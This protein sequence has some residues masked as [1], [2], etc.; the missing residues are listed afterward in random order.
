MQFN[1]IVATDKNGAIGKKGKIPWHYPEDLKFFKKTT[2]N[3]PV[4]MGRKTFES[5]PFKNGLPDRINI[6][7]TRN[8]DYKASQCVVLHSLEEVLKYLEDI[9]FYKDYDQC[10]C[11]SPQETIYDKCF[12]IGGGNIYKLFLD[13]DL[14]DKIYI[15]NIPED[16]QEADTFFP[17]IKKDYWH[18]NKEYKIQ[19][20]TIDILEN[21]C[22]KI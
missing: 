3:C 7:L 1:I 13:N 19:N 8:L 4:I 6:I 16:I 12:I 15:S 2:I 17:E 14:V 5:L 10:G 21:K 9:E 20:I 22:T 18:K 11:F